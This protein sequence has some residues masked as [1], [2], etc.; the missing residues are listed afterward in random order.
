MRRKGSPHGLHGLLNI[1][2]LTGGGAQTEIGTSL[3]LPNPLSTVIIV[4]KSCFVVLQGL[5]SSSML[6][7]YF[8][9][10]KS[11]LDNR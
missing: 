1:K 9:L 11:L 7:L 8:T 5:F 6:K 3:T 4:F 10:F 2:T